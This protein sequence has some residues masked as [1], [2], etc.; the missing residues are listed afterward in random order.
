[1]VVVGLAISTAYLGYNNQ[2]QAEAYRIQQTIVQAQ[3]EDLHKKDKHLDKVNQEKVDLGKEVADLH[4]QKED[5]I[6]DSQKAKEESDKL[7]AEV[8]K[9]EQDLKIKRE[10]EAKQAEK[11]AKQAENKAEQKQEQKQ[12]L[13]SKVTMKKD[14]PK[15][16][17]EPSPEPTKSTK[18]M[19][20]K[21]TH[22]SVGDS[23]TP[24]T[25]TANGTNVANTI[26]TAEGYRIIAVDPNVIPLN[27][28]VKL[29]IN[30]KTIIAKA[31][32]T[33]SAINGNKI[34]I[35]VGSPQE[36]LNLGVITLTVE[37]IG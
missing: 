20:F 9:L 3:K 15:P 37:I 18:A 30:G 28:I 2:Q 27:S 33:G 19:E 6:L 5:L 11:E 36:A 7:R 13:P 23:L 1:M 29:T 25:V 12:E 17:T 34:D 14:N 24:G 22:Y 26:Y 4:K 10:K 8:E 32:D 35:L 31:C 16:S 21:A